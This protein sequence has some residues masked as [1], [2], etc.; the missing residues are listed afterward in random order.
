MS[1]KKPAEDWE[2]I[3]RMY[4]AGTPSVR[5]IASKNNISE[6][7]IRKRAKE[8]GW[9]RDLTD[10][11]R[12]AAKARLVRTE[13]RNPY[14]QDEV[15][16]KSEIVDSAA[17]AL[18]QVVRSHRKDIAAGRMLV[19]TLLGQLMGVVEN[20]ECF[21]SIIEV[22]TAEDENPQRRAMMMKAISLP[23]H[24]STIRDL[25]QAMKNMIAL[26][27]QAFNLTDGMEPPAPNLPMVERVDDK[28][29][30]LK[31]AFSKVLARTADAG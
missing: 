23:V 17:E 15:R 29:E 2:A 28:L 19:Q 21:E 11:V 25:S 9:Q 16:T 18:V 3:K 27:R 8:F 22:A 10:E 14:A 13:V 5:A 1:A 30:A 24:A 26:E 4:R 31:A 7:A 6:G 20:R 12:A